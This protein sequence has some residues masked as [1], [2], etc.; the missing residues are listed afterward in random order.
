VLGY[1]G[2]SYGCGTAFPSLSYYPD[3][4]RTLR[5]TLKYNF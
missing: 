2:F 4:G 5:A 3:A 1:T